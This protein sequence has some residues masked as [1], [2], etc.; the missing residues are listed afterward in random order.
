MRSAVTGIDTTTDVPTKRSRPGRATCGGGG[1][2]EDPVF[3]QDLNSLYSR[4]DV[5]V[6]CLFVSKRSK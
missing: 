3:A 1:G 4:F 5:C 6:F 2:G